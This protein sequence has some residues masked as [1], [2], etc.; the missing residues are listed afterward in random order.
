MDEMR[1]CL[2]EKQ[3]IVVKVGSSTITHEATGNSS[4][5]LRGQLSGEPK[6]PDAQNAE[7]SKTLHIYKRKSLTYLIT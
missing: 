7:H 4:L 3:R 5:L 2:R 6:A 1:K